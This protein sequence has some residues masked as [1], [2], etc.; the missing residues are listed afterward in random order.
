MVRALQLTAAADPAVLAQYHYA[1]GLRADFGA[2]AAS[3][4]EALARG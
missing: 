4:F 3:R 1:F 2:L